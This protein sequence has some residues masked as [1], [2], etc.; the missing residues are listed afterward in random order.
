MARGRPL[1]PIGSQGLL[2]F[3]RWA[4]GKKCPRGFPATQARLNYYAPEPQCAE[5]EITAPT[6]VRRYN[7]SALPRPLPDLSMVYLRQTYECAFREDEDV[8][9]IAKAIGVEPHEVLPLAEEVTRWGGPFSQPVHFRREDEDGVLKWRLF[10]DISCREGLSPGT[11]YGFD[12]LSLGE[13]LRLVFEFALARARPDARYF[14]TLLDS[15]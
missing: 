5:L 14:P 10:V 8:A 1:S 6:F 11:E 4:G 12:Q 3:Q 13:K 2:V 15:R 9:K 7:N